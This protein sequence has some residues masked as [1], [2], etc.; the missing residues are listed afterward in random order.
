MSKKQTME[1]TLEELRAAE[2]KAIKARARAAAAEAKQRLIELGQ[3]PPRKAK[4]TKVV[5]VA[6][7][8]PKTGAVPPALVPAGP[9][10][11]ELHENQL[12]ALHE[13]Q[14]MFKQDMAETLLRMHDTF[15]QVVQNLSQATAQQAVALQAPVQESPT[16]KESE[17]I[18]KKVGE[19]SN[20]V[21]ELTRIIQSSVQNNQSD[22]N[23]VQNN[24]Q[25]SGA[26]MQNQQLLQMQLQL[27]ELTA[28]QRN[29]PIV[30][31]LTLS[32][33]NSLQNVLRVPSMVS[34]QEAPSER[35]EKE[36]MERELADARRA[37]AKAEQDAQATRERVMADARDSAEKAAAAARAEAEKFAAQAAA[38]Q[39]AA[40]Q[41]A[42][43]QAV[44]Q[45]V[46][47][48][49]VAPAPVAPAAQ[50]VV[51][52]PVAIAPVEA[53]AAAPAAVAPAAAAPAAQEVD[54]MEAMLAEMAKELAALGSKL[55]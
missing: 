10:V 23:G 38:I 41:A 18:Q 12:A 32:R 51:A 25:N 20:S 17:Q 4:E 24:M 44:P 30:E 5:Y 55:G 21:S 27:A 52:Q 11:T 47:A 33:M 3:V 53:V 39:A 36:R 13:A 50:T 2:V 35:A 54:P 19:L 46:V 49:P 40:P 42:A 28:V 45:V 14:I 31:I 6:D 43:V 48:Q 34:Q 26:A 15:D 16:K 8:Q 1:S 22:Q 7:A 29:A 9:S 37:A